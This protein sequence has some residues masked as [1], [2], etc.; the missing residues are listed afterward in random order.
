ME[1]KEYLEE[2]MGPRDKASRMAYM[3]KTQMAFDDAKDYIKK[4]ENKT[5]KKLNQGDIKTL[6]DILGT[7]GLNLLLR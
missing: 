1:F 6:I 3:L 2:A 5:K 7:D 4:I